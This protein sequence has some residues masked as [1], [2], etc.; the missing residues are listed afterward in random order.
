MNNLVITKNI[1]SEIYDDNSFKATAA[2]LLNSLIDAELQREEPDF[3][4]IDE[5]ADA[6]IEVQSDNLSSVIPF[7][8]N[9]KFNGDDKKRKTLGILLSC[10]VVFSLSLG[11]MAVNHTIEKNK[12]AQTTAPSTVQ[13][14]QAPTTTKNIGTT[15]ETTEKTAK[16]HAVDLE[17]NFPDSFKFDYLDFNDFTLDGITV[18]VEYSDGTVKTVN[19]NDCKV[20]KDEDFG[21]SKFLEKIVVEYEGVRTSFNVVFSCNVPP[22]TTP[23]PYIFGNL[24]DEPRN[25]Y[26]TDYDEPIEDGT[27]EDAL[28]TSENNY[29]DMP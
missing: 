8:A 23:P 3:D 28:N 29:P 18:N 2:A 9:N 24:T 1:L 21:K 14:T 11:A 4:F 19:I 10:A 22:I 27:T 15:A 13:T 16:P 12:E 20:I 5:C 6:L 7:I 25:E 26:P 17:L